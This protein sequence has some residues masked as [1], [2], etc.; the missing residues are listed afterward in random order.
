M[1]DIKSIRDN[2][3][4]FDAGLARRGL[5]PMSASL[6]AIDE[7]RRSAILASEQAQARRNAASKE[8]GEAKKAK[9]EA[10]AAKLMAEVAELKTT[11][12]ELEAAAKAADEELAKELSAIPNL[13]LAEVPDGVDEHGNVQRHVFGNRRNYAFAPKPHDDLGAALGDMDFETAAKLS[14]ARFVVLKK[15][16]ARLERA[17]GQFMLNLHTDEH[18]YTEINPPL[19][20]RNEIMFGTGQLPKFEDD[21]FWAIKGELLAAPDHERLQTERLGIIPTAEVAL[22]N[23]VRE[24]ILDEKQLPMRLTALTPCF[25]AEAGAAGRD[26][27]GMIRQHQFTKVELVSITTPETSKDEHERMLAC[28]E[29]VLR[30]LDLHYRVMTLCTGDMGFSSQKTYDIEVWMPGQGEGG[31]F[32]EISSCSVCGDFQARRMDARSRGPDGKPRFV[33]T[34][35]GS[36]TAL[37]RALIAVMETYQQEDGSIAVPDVLQPYMGG[38][39]VI[40][41]E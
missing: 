3:Q 37:G 21:Q 13:P 11:M 38:L 23:L 31:A 39:K 25:R 14:G 15:G 2:P 33:H 20:V 18:G 1:H 36:G 30:R 27:R 9:D 16:L 5:K 28:A 26:T 12:P 29:E 10:R 41:R 7:K 4:A 6:L 8:I 24:S 34:L 19:L 40:A 22:T 32:R 35:N 17:L